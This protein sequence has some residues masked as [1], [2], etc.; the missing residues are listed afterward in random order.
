VF[1]AWG[2]GEDPRLPGA[3]E[4]TADVLARATTFAR[5]RWAGGN[6]VTCTHN[7]VIRCL[8][9]S[10]LGVPQDQWH[11]LRVPHLAPVTFVRTRGHGLFVNIP[12]PVE[13]NLFA[14]WVPPSLREAA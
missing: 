4:S 11:R 6:T 12:E 5:D 3:G 13:R 14:G 10:V 7:V 9:G 8:V 2:R 1:A